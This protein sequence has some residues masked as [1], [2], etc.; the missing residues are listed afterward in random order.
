MREGK[1]KG[2][3]LVIYPDGTLYHIDLKRADNIPPSIFLVGAAERVDSFAKAFD[4]V[5]FQHRNSVRP[6]FYT[7]AG[8]YK[9]IPMA[10]I[11]TGIG[12][13]NIEIVMNELHAL[14]EYD[15]Q[16]SEWINVLPRVNIIRVG[17]CGASL[18]EIPAGAF[19]IS[20]YS[21]GL[22]NLGAYYPAVKRDATAKKIEDEFLKTI[23]GKTNPFSYVSPASADVIAAL[24]KSAKD[25][26]EEDP[27]LISGITTTSP[28]FFAPEGRKIGRLKTAF[29]LEQFVALIQK[30]EAEGL[31][32][33]NHEMETSILFR[34]CNEILGYRAGAICVVLDNLSSDEF[35]DAGFAKERIGKCVKVAL[36]A[37][38]KLT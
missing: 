35:I 5:F 6:E 2:S 1:A 22:D 33:I 36:G 19:A 7:V 18:K 12:P 25:A 29:S 16:K 31:K 26:G 24:E 28:G 13:D 34:L 20:R 30:F 4:S 38:V 37:M 3:E 21:I 9:D 10:A 14:F 11:S 17:T 32:I 23:V 8:V 15:H 27:M